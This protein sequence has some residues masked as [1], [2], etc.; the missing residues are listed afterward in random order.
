MQKR[1]QAHPSVLEAQ[2]SPGQKEIYL[3][4][5]MLNHLQRQSKEAQ[6]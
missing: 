3:P 5:A 2:Q 1:Y 6:P 4:K